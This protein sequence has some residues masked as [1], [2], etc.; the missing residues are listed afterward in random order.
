M[1]V[2]T[3]KKVDV[4][5][6]SLSLLQA[7]QQRDRMVPI[8]NQESS[9][10][11]HQTNSTA[12]DVAIERNSITDVAAQNTATVTTTSSD[13]SYSFN[14]SSGTFDQFDYEE[15]PCIY[16]PPNSDDFEDVPPL[17]PSQGRPPP[18]ST[19]GI[20]LSTTKTSTILSR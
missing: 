10:T 20:Y 8:N 11:P 5:Q 14:D 7:N 2:K 1:Q 19:S 3:L 4:I 13:H 6:I 15:N 12:S 18:T 9:G 17:P 16:E